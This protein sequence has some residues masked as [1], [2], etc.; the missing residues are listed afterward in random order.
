ME[1]KE[2][3][4]DFKVSIDRTP[5]VYLRWT[6]TESGRDKTDSYERICNENLT[7]YINCDNRNS[8]I[9]EGNPFFD[10]LEELYNEYMNEL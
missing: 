3:I 9:C 7:Y 10:T 8:V 4:T 6:N 5:R 2:Q 1:F